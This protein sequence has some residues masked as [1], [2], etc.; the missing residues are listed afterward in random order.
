MWR[1]SGTKRRDSC[2]N[3][4]E[5]SVELA[6]RIIGRT[7][8]THNQV[9]VVVGNQKGFITHIRKAVVIIYV[10]DQPV[11]SRPTEKLAYSFDLIRS[12][13]KRRST[14][15]RMDRHLVDQLLRPG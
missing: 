4:S 15:Q 14:N 3:V 8:R 5:L 10:T 1:K 2:F 13:T 7:T 9:D 6:A 12:Q 11:M